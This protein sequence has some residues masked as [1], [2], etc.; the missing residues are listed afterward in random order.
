MPSPLCIASRLSLSLPSHLV[1][2]F[3]RPAVSTTFIR[4]ATIENLS[5]TTS[6][7]EDRFAFAHKIALDLFTFMTSFSQSSQPGYMMVPTNMFDQWMQRF[8]RKYR[9]DPNFMMKTAPS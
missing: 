7:V 9:L 1:V 6:G 5:L 8:E 3:R 4:L 2:V